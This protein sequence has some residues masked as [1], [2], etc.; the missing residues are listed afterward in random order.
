MALATPTDGVTN[1]RTLKLAHSA[2]VEASEVI[3]SGGNVLIAVCAA[4]ISVANA[5]IFRGKALFPKGAGAIAAGVKIYWDE[6]AGQMTTTSTDNIEAGIT[7]EAAPSADT[8]VL[9]VLH[10]N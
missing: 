8:E 1:C 9:V 10:E 6:S 7:G 4:L 3:V 5:Y 2:A